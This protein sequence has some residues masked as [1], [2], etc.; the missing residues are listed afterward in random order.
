MIQS[1]MLKNVTQ[2]LSDLDK[3]FGMTLAKEN[4]HDR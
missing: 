2:G 1:N 3:F 4:G